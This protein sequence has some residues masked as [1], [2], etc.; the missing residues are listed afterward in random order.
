MFLS[1]LP[2]ILKKTSLLL[3][4]LI[5]AAQP[6]LAAESSDKPALVD[7]IQSLKKDVLKLNRDLFILEEDLLFP[8]NIQVSVF[9]S[10]DAGLLFDLDSVQ[11]K[12]NDTVVANHLY[13]ER[14]LAALKRGG[15]Q[16]LYIGNLASGTHELVA[17]FVGKGPNNRDYRRGTTV[18]L[19]KGSDPLFIELKIADDVSKEQPEFTAKTWQ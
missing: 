13:T 1:K 15:V 9:L 7:D 10:M 12:L 2:S 19:N 6:A 17:I 4:V 8:A 18:E 16:R 3:L 11:L 5:A 14:Q